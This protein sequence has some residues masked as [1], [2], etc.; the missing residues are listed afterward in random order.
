MT[1]RCNTPKDTYILFQ[2]AA[3]FMFLRSS[4]QWFLF[5]S[6]GVCFIICPRERRGGK[7]VTF[8]SRSPGLLLRFR[9]TK[10]HG[11]VLLVFSRPPL[12]PLLGLSFVRSF[13][14]CPRLFVCR[15]DTGATTPDDR[16]DELYEH[17]GARSRDEREKDGPSGATATCTQTY[18]LYSVARPYAR[19]RK[20]TGLF[21][22]PSS[23][24]SS[25]T[26]GT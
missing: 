21:M 17:P 26:T 14:R 8:Q 4:F 20:P 1:D 7:T 3:L 15:T 13:L 25:R 11:L 9:G 6:L 16:E 18:A 24:A 2:P 12:S 23:T 22:R 5:W 19:C 10:L